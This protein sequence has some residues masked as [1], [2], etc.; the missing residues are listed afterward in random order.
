MMNTL[1]L[2]PPSFDGYDGG[3]G[4]RYQNKR[5]IK[6]FWYPTWLAQPAALVE[7]SKLIDGPP[8][9]WT[10][11]TV[12]ADARTRDLVVMH[13]STPSFEQDVKFARALKDIKP[14]LQIG[15]IGAKVA[16]DP[17]GSLAASD[18]IDWVARNEFDFTCQDV[19][20]GDPLSGIDGISFRNK[21]GVIVHNRDRAIITDMDQLPWVHAGLRAR[22]PH[23]RLLHRLSEAS[24]Y[25]LLH[26]PRL[27]IALHLLLVAADRW[28]PQLPRPQRRPCGGRSSLRAEGLPA[29]EGNLLRRRYADR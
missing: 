29:D 19:A 24:V 6:S 11:E 18:A 4:A 28:R 7:G 17:Q 3:A 26:R 8:S 14:S 20:R 9:G 13:T 5:E 23:R 10:F 2:Q 15:M 21:D 22:P 27:Q 1:F 12:A 25:Q 16:V